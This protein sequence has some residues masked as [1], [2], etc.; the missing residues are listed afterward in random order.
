MIRLLYIEEKG[1]LGYLEKQQCGVQFVRSLN[2]WKIGRQTGAPYL[3]IKVVNVN[4]SKMG[5]SRHRSE[6]HTLIKN[7]D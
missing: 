4:Q 5:R 6:Q 3:R 2:L 7:V 1:I